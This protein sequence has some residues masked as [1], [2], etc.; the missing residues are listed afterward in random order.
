MTSKVFFVSISKTTLG[1]TWFLSW[2]MIGY[3]LLVPLTGHHVGPFLALV[4]GFFGTWA[5]AIGIRSRFYPG[6][7]SISLVM[8]G[9][10][11]LIVFISASPLLGYLGLTFFSLGA[12]CSAIS[13]SAQAS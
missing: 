5:S 8:C 11:F 10:T 9:L 6:F 12:A 7:V 13:S 1:L 3:V 4:I 2:I